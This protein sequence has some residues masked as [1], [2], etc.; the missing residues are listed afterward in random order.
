MD[1]KFHWVDQLLQKIRKIS[2]FVEMR[3]GYS[4]ELNEEHDEPFVVHEEAMQHS[5]KNDRRA[6]LQ[7]T[8]WSRQEKR[9]L[10]LED[11]KP[12]PTFSGSLR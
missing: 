5:D 3:V 9:F 12:C 10:C 7:A 4:S 11:A 1:A 8:C 6:V 2:N